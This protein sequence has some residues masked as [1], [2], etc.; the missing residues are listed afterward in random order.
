MEGVLAM[1]AAIN[2]LREPQGAGVELVES[3]KVIAHDP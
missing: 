1:P 2:E 3:G